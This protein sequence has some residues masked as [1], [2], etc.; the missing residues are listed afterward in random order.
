MDRPPRVLAIDVLRG[1]DVL[2]M[3]FVNEMAG[4]HGTPAFLLHKTANDDGMT[5]TDVVFP[6]FLFI[7]GMA[8]PLALGG[9]RRR[10]P[11][12]SVWRHVLTRT[13]ALLIIG[14]LMVNT[15]SAGSGGILSPHL[16]SILMYLGVVLVWMVPGQ[17]EGAR[18]RV[19][20]KLVGV[21]LLVFLVLAY[22]AEGGSGLV[23]I[24]PSW[25][26]I[27]G[28]IGWS[29]LVGAALYLVAGD[30]PA[31]FV[32]ATA[33]LY[34]VYAADA[35]SAIGWLVAARPVVSVGTALASHGA[36]TVS[37]ALVT[38]LLM[39]ARA[40]GEPPLRFA[41][42]A[43]AMAGTFALAGFLVHSLHDLHPAFE[44]NKIRATAAW[45][46]LCSAATLAVWVAV[47]LV[48]DVKGGRRWPKDVTTA[49]ENALVIYLLAP[50]LLS[51]FELLG[52]LTGKNPYA[53]LGASLWIGLVRSI[54][55]AWVVV[56]LSGWMRSRGLRLQL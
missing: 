40:A 34:L 3:L 45:C 33:L 14:V 21:A 9:R 23:Q 37:G 55:F 35:T 51:V 6:A 36:L 25:W 19:P 50:F 43:L 29:Y 7:V 28:L 56:R 27:L 17:A 2:L 4:V 41:W 1:L 39:R 16:W 15:E 10:E 44:I 32:A 13:A 11:R 12:S 48:S 42:T 26:G 31:V 8:I 30:R 38:L 20:W 52:S 47:Y 18:S 53:A 49:G 22:R 54:V 46:L 5:I 24:R